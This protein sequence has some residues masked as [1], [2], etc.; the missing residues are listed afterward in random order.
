MDELKKI[1][2]TKNFYIRYCQAKIGHKYK[3][4]LLTF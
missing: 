4:F 2:C 1:I 3:T